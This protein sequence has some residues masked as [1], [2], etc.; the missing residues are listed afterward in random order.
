MKKKNNDVRRHLIGCYLV[1]SSFY[2]VNLGFPEVAMDASSFA[3]AN[4]KAKNRA[5]VSIFPVNKA[6]EALFTNATVSSPFRWTCIHEG[7]FK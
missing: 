6:K 7:A 2:G 3:Y 4:L 5:S 1:S